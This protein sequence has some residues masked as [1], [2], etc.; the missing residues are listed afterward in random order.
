MCP[1]NYMP[2]TSWE[3]PGWMKHKSW[4]P[5]MAEMSAQLT[6]TS[7][8]I[9]IMIKRNKEHLGESEKEVSD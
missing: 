8:N 2:S 7:D 4:N 3:I 1:A 6:L 5:K 9:L